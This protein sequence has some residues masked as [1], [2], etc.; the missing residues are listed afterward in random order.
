MF[1]GDRLQLGTF[2]SI[3]H[4]VSASYITSISA[5]Y[6]KKRYVNLVGGVLS[7][8]LREGTGRNDFKLPRKRNVRTFR[9]KGKAP[10]NPRGY[11]GPYMLLL[12]FCN[13]VTKHR[14]KVQKQDDGEYVS[15]I[16]VYPVRAETCFEHARQAQASTSA[17]ACQN[18]N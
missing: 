18:R 12:D 7:W 4:F 10:I 1:R 16:S 8:M 6:L 2:E 17:A 9:M 15:R 13:G 14:G 11:S 5:S 3:I